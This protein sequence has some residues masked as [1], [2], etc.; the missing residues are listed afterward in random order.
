MG[1]Q[2]FHQDLKI[3]SEKSTEDDGVQK[4]KALALWKI[5]EIETVLK[6]LSQ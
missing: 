2:C 6:R 1:Q 5:T 4:D 3:I